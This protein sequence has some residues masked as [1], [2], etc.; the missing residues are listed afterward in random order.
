MFL[1]G[2]MFCFYL[3][4]THEYIVGYICIFIAVALDDTLA[5]LL[6]FTGRCKHLPVM[7]SR[8]HRGAE[9]RRRRPV[10]FQVCLRL[11]DVGHVSAWR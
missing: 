11:G 10:T 8:L 4:R 2:L 9:Q 3:Q 1:K 6:Q 7:W 5:I